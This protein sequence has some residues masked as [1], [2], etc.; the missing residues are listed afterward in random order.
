M[1][2]RLVSGAGFEH[3]VFSRGD[4]R[5]TERIHVYLEGDGLPWRSRH[6]I[7]S[8][9]TPRNPLALRLMALDPSP[10]IY[11]GRP[12]YFGLAQADGCSPWLWTDAR[13]GAE[14][15]DSMVAALKALL[16]ADGPPPLTLIGY[17][18]GGVLAALMAPRL[19]GEVRVVTLA[20][21]LDID[22]WADHHGYSRLSGSI[23][24]A[25][26]P[27]IG[28]SIMQLHLMGAR[29]REVPP[30]TVARFMAVNPGAQRRLF[31]D[32]DHR[33][34]WLDDWPALLLLLDG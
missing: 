21:N 14:V 20:A 34:C 22:A 8:D 7:A 3:V 19:G 12:C 25:N 24:P 26:E 9:P 4:L 5:T 11:L 29:D 23:N 1:A 17:S 31:S 18:G 2:R 32:S 16:P 28:A 10:S 13:Y 27:P 33:C 6:R 15:V 30:A